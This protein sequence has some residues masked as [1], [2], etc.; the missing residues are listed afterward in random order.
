MYYLYVRI[1]SLNEHIMDFQCDQIYYA[2]Y[3]NEWY[4]MNLKNAQNMILIMARTNKSIHLS[5][6]KMFPLTMATFSNVSYL[7]LYVI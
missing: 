6:G 4:T 5:V 2:T 3:S 1:F 7:K